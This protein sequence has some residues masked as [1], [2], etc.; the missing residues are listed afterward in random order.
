MGTADAIAIV[1]SVVT[2]NTTGTTAARTLKSVN[3]VRI[4]DSRFRQ[5]YIRHHGSRFML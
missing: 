2:C 1:I 3:Q 5:Q 4:Y